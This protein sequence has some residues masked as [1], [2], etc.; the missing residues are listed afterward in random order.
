MVA[1][2]GLKTKFE[3][4]D[5]LLV[6]AMGLD[7]GLLAI[8][9]GSNPTLRF[10][11]KV[12]PSGLWVANRSLIR[13]L[14]C[15]HM[16][17]VVHGI[18]GVEIIVNHAYGDVH[19]VRFQFGQLYVVSTYT[20][21]V[22]QLDGAGNLVHQWKFPGENDSWHLN[23]LDLW[24]GRYVVSCFGRFERSRQYKED[25]VGA[26]IVFDLETQETLW[27]GLSYPHTPRMDSEGRQYICD[28]GTNRLLRRDPDGSNQREICFPQAFTRGMA[29]GRNRIYVGLS[30]LRVQPVQENPRHK[31]IPNARIAV[32]DKETLEIV[33]EIDLPCLEIYD[34]VCLPDDVGF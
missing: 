1:S 10:V 32:L 12:L 31:C 33:D 29:F 22:V 8:A 2:Q 16:V 30:S 20:N 9:K 15:K 27:D 28:S 21:E 24:N 26:G 23:C 7:G 18:D 5:N 25:G 6:S 34:I 17:L 11:D 19:D 3:L 14:Y 13:A 4:E